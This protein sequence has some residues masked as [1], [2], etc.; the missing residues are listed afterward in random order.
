MKLAQVPHFVIRNPRCVT[1]NRGL[2]P[3]VVAVNVPRRDQSFASRLAE[4][5]D[6]VWRADRVNARKESRKFCWR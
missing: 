4:G 6:E 1:Q 3:R 2:T 5:R